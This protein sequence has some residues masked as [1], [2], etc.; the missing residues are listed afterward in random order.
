[1][2]VRSTER[3]RSLGNRCRPDRK[4][5]NPNPP[6]LYRSHRRLSRRLHIPRSFPMPKTGLDALLRPEDSIL[7]LIDHQPYQF[8]NLNS[9]EPTITI[10]TVIPLPHTAKLFTLPP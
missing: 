7:V 10:N 8:T 1:M 5:P 4:R 9:H 6:C 2:G 3:S